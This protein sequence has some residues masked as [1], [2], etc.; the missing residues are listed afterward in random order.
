MLTGGF[1]EAQTVREQQEQQLTLQ[2]SHNVL[3]GLFD[4][5]HRLALLLHPTPDAQWELEIPD[6]LSAFAL[7]VNQ[8][9]PL[10][11][12]AAMLDMAA[13]Y[14]LRPAVV[15]LIWNIISQTIL[16]TASGAAFSTGVL[17]ILAAMYSEEWGPF[18]KDDVESVCSVQ[19]SL[20]ALLLLYCDK[21]DLAGA[22][23]GSIDTFFDCLS[24]LFKN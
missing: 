8:K 22:I 20:S 16:Q 12:Q 2:S 11:D 7:E 23:G 14:E 19:R 6:L 1:S 5:F 10:E 17:E 4:I 18:F 24:F 13:Y 9:H 15:F 3:T 21:I